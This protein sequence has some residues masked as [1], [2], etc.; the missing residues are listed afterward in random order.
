MNVNI[1]KDSIYPAY[2]I[3]EV[4]EEIRDKHMYD[5]ELPTEK[6][7]EI[8]NILKEYEQAQ[9]YLSNLLDER[10]RLLRTEHEEK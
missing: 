5:I 1:R 8:K 3:G 7:E 9:T 10:Y 6:Y 2:S 4:L